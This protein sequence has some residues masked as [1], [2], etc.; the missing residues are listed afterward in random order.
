MT[1]R[2]GMDALALGDSLSAATPAQA[3]SRVE[4]LAEIAS[5]KNADDAITVCANL[6][7]RRA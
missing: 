1:F 5:F 6:C 2:V 3:A 7:T 4:P